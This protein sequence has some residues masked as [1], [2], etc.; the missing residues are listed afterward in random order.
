MLVE[1][2]SKTKAGTMI[3]TTANADKA[4]GDAGE[5]SDAEQQKEG[6][7]VHGLKFELKAE[8]ENTVLP[9]PVV[10]AQLQ[11]ARSVPQYLASESEARAPNHR[12]GCCQW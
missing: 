9:T 3:I 10:D 1:P 12:S 4:A 6:L 5:Q 2:Q 11:S 7:N 8:V